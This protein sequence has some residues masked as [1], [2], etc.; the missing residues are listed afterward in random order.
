MDRWKQSKSC[1]YNTSYHFIWCPKYR[2]KVLKGKI[3]TRLKELILK[4][5]KE[6][7]VE[8]GAMEVMEDHVHIFVKA[9]PVHSPQ[10]LVSQFKGYTSHE[11]RKQFPEL[12]SKLPTLWTRSY[13]VES[14]G[15]ISQKTVEK[16]I[17]DQKNK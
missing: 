4:K 6:I 2:R 15:H 13:Y 5:A 8:I 11:L 16:Y 9:R 3:E 10:Y 14:I 17:Q 1:V 12:I 7:N